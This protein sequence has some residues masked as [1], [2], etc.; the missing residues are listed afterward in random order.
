MTSPQSSPQPDPNQLAKN[1]FISPIAKY[2]GEFTPQNL[3][4]NANLQEFA[5]RVSIICALETSGKLTPSEAYQQIHQLWDALAAS[6]R[7]LLE[8][9]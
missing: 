4:F 1:A 3:A 7:N 8:D 5:N 2:G 6:E 9:A